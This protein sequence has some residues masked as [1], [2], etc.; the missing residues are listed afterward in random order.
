MLDMNIPFFPAHRSGW[1]RLRVPDRLSP[2]RFS[3]RIWFGISEFNHRLIII[4]TQRHVGRVDDARNMRKSAD[5]CQF[6]ESG[7]VKFVTGDGRLDWKDGW[8][9]HLHKSVPPISVE[10]LRQVAC[11]I[12]RRPA[13]LGRGQERTSKKT[14][15]S[16]RRRSFHVPL[17]D[18]PKE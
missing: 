3:Y 15:S 16:P 18:L 6:I 11:W 2:S 9:Q 7:K 13:Y 5:S 12:Q 14:G 10:Q 4:I 8:V 17:T 1:L